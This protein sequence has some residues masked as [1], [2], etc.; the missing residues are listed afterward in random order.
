[1]LTDMSGE[2]RDKITYGELSDMLDNLHIN[3]DEASCITV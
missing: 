1:M 2:K 3:Y